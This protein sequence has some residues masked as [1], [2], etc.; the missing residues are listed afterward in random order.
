MV[1]RLPRPAVQDNN[2]Y[3]LAPTLKPG[4][5]PSRIGAALKVRESI[6]DSDL[7]AFPLLPDLAVRLQRLISPKR[8]ANANANPN[9]SALAR[10]SPRPAT[11]QPVMIAG[12][13]PPKIMVARPQTM[14]QD[15]AT[16]AG[17]AV[18]PESARG[19][20]HVFVRARPLSAR[21]RELEG[22]PC[23][24][25]ANGCDVFVNE[26]CDSKDYLRQKR[27]KSRQFTFDVAF[28]PEATQ[29]E[30]YEASAATLI[31]DILDG[32]NACCFCYGATGAGKVRAS[33]R[34]LLSSLASAA[35]HPN[36]T[37]AP[38]LPTSRA[39]PT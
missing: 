32:R 23:V 35:L 15:D 27:I 20:I 16:T 1:I 5:S 36:R 17:R 37:R 33:L 24:E 12:Q 3:G 34:R 39:A 19:R 2:R 30:V 13:P 21:E 18:R 8:P 31:D 28:G 10:A 11:A 25:V 9:P 29:Q 22:F 38:L 7:P 4:M 14:P 6:H 26:F